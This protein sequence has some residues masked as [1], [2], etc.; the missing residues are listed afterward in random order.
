MTEGFLDFGLIQKMDP[1]ARRA[2]A[3]MEAMQQAIVHNN[4]DDVGKHLEDA[5]NALAVLE[6][7]LSL[8]KSFATTAA[9]SK[10]DDGVLGEGRTLGNVAVHKNTVSDYDGTEGATVL[11]VSRLGRSSTFWR[12]QME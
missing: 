9:I 5:K 4:M 8:A 2:V 7:D 1:M 6:G 11:G 12:P 3:S 10:S